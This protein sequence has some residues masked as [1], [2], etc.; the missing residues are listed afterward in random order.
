[1]FF[2]QNFPIEIEII[3]FLW[4]KNIDQFVNIMMFCQKFPIEMSKALFLW[5]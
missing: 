1:M 5:E 4:E 3:N 2:D